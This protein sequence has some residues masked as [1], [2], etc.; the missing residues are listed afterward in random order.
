MPRKYL[1]TAHSLAERVRVYWTDKGL[2]VDS[3]EGY[4]IRRTRVLFEEVQLVTL[5]SQM[6][7]AMSLLTF[8]LALLVGIVAS[9]L[10]R[11]EPATSRGMMWVALVLAVLAAL[12]F[13]LPKWVITVFGRRSRARLR[14]RLR[15]AKARDLFAHICQAVDEAQRNLRPNV[16]PAP[17]LDS[18]FGNPEPPP[19]PLSDSE[20]PIAPR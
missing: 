15:E 9:A 17:G 4:E 16:P 13:V 18:G 7:G 14:I 8:I 10:T 2:E 5:H 20:P 1:G 19:L 12:L 6:G 3:S 11:S